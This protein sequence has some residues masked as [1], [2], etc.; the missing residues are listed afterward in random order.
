[1]T[2]QVNLP[3]KWELCL[4][5]SK[6]DL[7]IGGMG[8]HGEDLVADVKIVYPLALFNIEAAAQKLLSTTNKE[9]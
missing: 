6:V 1:M 4:L 5:R 3:V 7:L 8:S 2:Q 9:E